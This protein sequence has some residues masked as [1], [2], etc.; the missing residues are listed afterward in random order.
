MASSGL[1][2][3]REV[4]VR[5]TEAGRLR[6][7]LALLARERKDVLGQIGEQV[8]ALVDE[9]ELTIPEEVRQLYDRVKDL[10]TRMRAD[11]AK[12]KDNAFG[13]PR[14]YEPE[15]GNFEDDEPDADDP[16]PPA[17]TAT[18]DRGKG[19]PR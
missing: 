19:D 2:T 6:V 13:A 8:V 7:D 15:A 12:A 10:D 1:D 14:G 3:L 18:A 16:S 4:V 17:D 9:G 5:S 11:S